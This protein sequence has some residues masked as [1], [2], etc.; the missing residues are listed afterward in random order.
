MNA[1]LKLPRGF[2]TAA[3]AAGIKAS[4][5]PDCALIAAD[6]PLRWALAATTNTLQAACVVRNRALF[7]GER[8]VRAVAIN[9]GNANCATGEAGARANGAFAAAA[10]A[11]LGVAP[12]EVLTASTGVIGEPLPVDKLTAALPRLA[13]ALTDDAAGLAQ[14]ILTT[15]LVPKV[16]E[17][18]LEGGARIVG[19]AKGSGMI[20][21]NMATM[22]AFVMTDADLPQGALR[23]LW[24]EVVAQSFNQISVDGDTSPNDMAFLLANPRV[25]VREA[26]FAEA[27]RR[28]AREL[29]KRIARDG[30][31][32][33]KL[34]CVRVTGA[35]SDAE[36]RRAARAVVVSPLVKAAAH[37]CDPNWGRVLSAVGASG[38]PL[39]LPRL[40]LRVQ[41]VSVYAGAPA[42]FD[43]A[44]VSRKMDAEE[45]VLELDLA[46][47]SGTG[48]AWGCDLSAEYVTINADYH[49]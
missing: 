5:R 10:A 49:T 41:G 16:A 31:G 35:S 3:L 12:D 28:V 43:A 39:A 8:A 20:H 29:A 7:T 4:G 44:A 30:E 17:A 38:V 1:T 48:E 2:R 36:A 37:G 27:L 19:V 40:S 42:P 46:A 6:A 47:G 24:P 11:A 21:P 9:S 33:T 26:A 13:A 32:A 14:A 22:F 18:R 34:L 23:A 45:L 15:D 25:A